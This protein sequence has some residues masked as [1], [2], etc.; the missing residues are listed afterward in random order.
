M[1]STKI[2]YAILSILLI[3]PTVLSSFT[4]KA[5]EGAYTIDTSKTA[6]LTIQ[7]NDDIEGKAAV[8]GAEFTL[9]KIADFTT[10][11]SSGNL[12]NEFNSIIPGVDFTG[13]TIGDASKGATTI[14]INSEKSTTE[15]TT[16]TD[17]TD[18]TS[19][20]S[21]GSE[22]D[23]SSILDKVKKAYES[24]NFGIKFQL[25]TDASGKASVEMKSEAFG[26]YLVE[27]TK[28]APHH[29]ASAPFIATLPYT[30]F[31]ENKQTVGWN[32]NLTV[33]PKS[34]QL[35]DLIIE[36]KLEGDGVNKDDVFNFTITL[37][38]D[39][40]EL[41][42]EFEY[43]K[44]DKTTGKIKSGGSIA[45]KGGETATIKDIPIGISYKVVEKEA[46]QNG[47]K[48]TS[49]G[50]EG[51]IKFSEQQKAV[52]TNKKDKEVT[53]EQKTTETPKTPETPNNTP[54]TSV[55]TDDYILPGIIIFMVFIVSGLLAVVNLINGRRK[56]DEK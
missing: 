16:K 11:T 29:S 5:D 27:E 24:E 23:A 43:E 40:A 35:G 54:D 55:K 10:Y 17:K 9:Y 26:L 46:D 53:T 18:K 25:K 13:I 4:V 14:N 42:D 15:S 45:L 36:K 32:Y 49:T 7:Y 39:K 21:G 28:A 20:I 52:F 12:G 33:Y 50:N 6:T 41:T 3:I 44:S 22:V 2:K 47:Y 8:E 51:H 56:K 34:S 48:T 1:I 19:T 30:E 31:N 38:S 37:K